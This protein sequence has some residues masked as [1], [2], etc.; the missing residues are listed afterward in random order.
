MLRRP[1]GTQQQTGRSGPHRQFRMA[2]CGRSATTR[3]LR[4]A[5]RAAA[6]QRGSLQQCDG[7]A[8][9]ERTVRSVSSELRD[10]GR[11]RC[12]PPIRGQ[13]VHPSDRFR[14]GISAAFLR[15][16]VHHADHDHAPAGGY[17]GGP[18]GRSVRISAR[19]S[20]PVRLVGPAQSWRLPQ[21]RKLSQTLPTVGCRIGLLIPQRSRRPP[22]SSSFHLIRVVLQAARMD[23]IQS[24]A[25][26]PQVDQSPVQLLSLVNSTSPDV[27]TNPQSFQ[28]R[29]HPCL[30]KQNKT[31]QNKTK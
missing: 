19:Q 18:S 21:F 23:R 22:Y 10:D 9:P 24:A 5:P 27:R 11:Q 30:Q 4:P 6:I 25:D 29:N 3:L 8:Q 2:V 28:V 20:S 16:H 7:I 13:S 15:S 17:I 31:K 14:V 12:V 26:T 1:E